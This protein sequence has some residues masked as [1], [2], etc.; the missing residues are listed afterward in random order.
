[1]KAAVL[2]DPP[3]TLPVGNRLNEALKSIAKAPVNDKRCATSAHV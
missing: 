3:A 2:P 1:M